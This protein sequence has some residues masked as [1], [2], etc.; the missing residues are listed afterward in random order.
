MRREDMVYQL[1]RN[2]AKTQLVY[3]TYQEDSSQLK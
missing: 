1:L 3:R 2:A